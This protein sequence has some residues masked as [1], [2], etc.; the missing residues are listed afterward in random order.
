[1]SVKVWG[2]ASRQASPRAATPP[3]PPS[4]RDLRDCT[5][6]PRWGLRGKVCSLC[7]TL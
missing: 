5:D 4:H 3:S 7:K 2:G 1:M 6:C